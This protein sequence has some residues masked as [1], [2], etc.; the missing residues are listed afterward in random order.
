MGVSNSPFLYNGI[1]YV[2][3]Q[4]VVPLVGGSVGL[5]GDRYS[6]L[7]NGQSYFLVVGSRRFYRGSSLLYL[8]GPPLLVGE[9]I[10]VPASS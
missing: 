9:V 8:P 6:V 7:Y 1:T 2:P 5:R 10:F 4:S 3:L